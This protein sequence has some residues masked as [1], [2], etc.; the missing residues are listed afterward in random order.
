MRPALPWIFLVFLFPVPWIAGQETG[1]SGF[2]TNQRVRVIIDNDF[3][4]DPDG[5]FQL[6]H[7]LLSPS[8]ETR[9]IIATRHYPDGFYGRPGTAA[10]GVERARALLET[11]GLA[12]K[13][14]LLAGS[15]SPLPDDRTPVRSAGV[16]FILRECARGDTKSPL[17]L[18]C[19]AGLTEAAS[20]LLR[21]PGIA[22]KVHIVWIGGPE[23]AGLAKPPPGKRRVEYNLGIDIAAARVVFNHSRVPL[24]QVPRDAYR[25][26]LVSDAELSG[27][28]RDGGKLGN[29]LAGELADLKKR[30]GGTLGETYVLGDNPLVLLTALQSSWEPDACSSRSVEVPAPEITEDGWYGKGDS[31]RVIRVFT[32]LDTRLMFED[33]EA[34][35][36][37]FG[38]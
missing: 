8:V 24:W 33:L 1:P 28:F 9:A 31:N 17:Y 19:G 36:R 21:E 6:A 10:H 34:K 12:G 5:L 15:E 13:F 14:P 25:Q 23:H 2:A 29:F 37:A 7:H 16:D 27:R 4:G 35:V 32:E 11:M 3:G 30:A 18:V 38:P 26:A 22:E 20:A